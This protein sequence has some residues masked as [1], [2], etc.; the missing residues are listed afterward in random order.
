M[1][2]LT[3]FDSKRIVLNADLIEFVEETPDTV[4]SLTDGKKVMVRESVGQVVERVIRY[5]QM[6]SSAAVAVRDGRTQESVDADLEEL[7]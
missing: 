2:T 3:L 7:Q 5:K 6:L 1:I 4:I